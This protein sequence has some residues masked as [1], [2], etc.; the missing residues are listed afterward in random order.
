[1]K[2]IKMEMG[3]VMNVIG[4]GE[5]RSGPWVG[6]PPDASFG[7]YLIEAFQNQTN[8]EKILYNKIC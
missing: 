5:G 7:F 2:K 3:E 1:M 6:G 8:T 4:G